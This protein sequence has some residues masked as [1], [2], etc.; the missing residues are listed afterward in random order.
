MDT[1]IIKTEDSNIVIERTTIDK[2]I[3]INDLQNTIVAI[4]EQLAMIDLKINQLKLYSVPQEIEYI[5]NREINEL[6]A[7]KIGLE[8]KLSLA[9][10]DLLKI[11]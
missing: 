6:E 4:T 5:I 10:E 11:N 3:N 1:E 2:E 8:Y 9:N 7:V